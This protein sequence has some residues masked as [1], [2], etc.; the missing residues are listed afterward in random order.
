M[1]PEQVMKRCQIGTNNYEAA[2]QLHAECYGTIGKLVI[3]RDELLHALEELLAGKTI[4]GLRGHTGLMDMQVAGE[5]VRKGLEAIALVKE[6]T[7]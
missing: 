5:D 7:A 1:T 3:Q 2:N 4:E 6:G